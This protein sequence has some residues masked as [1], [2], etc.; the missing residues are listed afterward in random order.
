MMNNVFVSAVNR[1]LYIR[2]TSTGTRNWPHNLTLCVW[3]KIIGFQHISHSHL[4]LVVLSADISWC[5]TPFIRPNLWL[6][7]RNTIH[8]RRL[9]SVCTGY[10]PVS[11]SGDKGQFWDVQL[12]Q[13]KSDCLIQL[14]W[15]TT[16]LSRYFTGFSDECEPHTLLGFT[17]LEQWTL[18]STAVFFCC[19]M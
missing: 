14:M 17:E 8:Q 18:L 15:S 2:A 4:L 7:P 6:H 13:T 3:E 11:F 19:V 10:T 12:F 16:N 5:P 1:H 9:I